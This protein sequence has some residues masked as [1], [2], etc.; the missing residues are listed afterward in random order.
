MMLSFAF[1]RLELD[2]VE[3]RADNNNLRSLAAMKSIGCIMEG[4]LRSNCAS[5]NGRR[6]SAVL[7]ILKEEWDISVKTRL[8][9]KCQ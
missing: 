4:V 6:D 3:F 1:D 5:V 2:R 7:S 8:G 9:G